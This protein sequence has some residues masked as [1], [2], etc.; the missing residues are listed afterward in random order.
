MLSMNLKYSR[1]YKQYIVQTSLAKSLAE[2][3]CISWSKDWRQC[4]NCPIDL[5]EFILVVCINDQLYWKTLL[6]IVEFS[7]VYTLKP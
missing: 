3:T 2:N 5:T 4:K 7:M 1:I 6:V